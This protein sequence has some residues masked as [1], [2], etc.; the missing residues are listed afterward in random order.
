MIYKIS[1][2]S[3][4]SKNEKSEEIQNLRPVAL[5]PIPAK[6]L[7]AV[8]HADIFQQIQH[9][10]SPCQH[11]FY[12]SRGVQTNLISYIQYVLMEFDEGR[13]VDAIG[14]TD[15]SKAFDKVNHRLL[16]QKMR[17]L[18]FS[19]ESVRL[20]TSYLLEDRF[21]YVG[22]SGYESVKFDCPSGVPKGSNLGP[23]L[24]IIFINDV[25][26]SIHSSCILTLCR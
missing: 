2:I 18:S 12:C 7:E 16:L 11:G 19:E 13:Q 8:F 17:R 4:V 10:I 9:R 23:F 25:V 20:F 6:I 21:Q 14:Y 26:D 24:F 15:F 5:L 3:P 22:Y 1:K